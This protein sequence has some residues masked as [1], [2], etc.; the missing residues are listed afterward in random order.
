LLSNDGARIWKGDAAE[1]AGF[2]LSLLL[3]TMLA[4]R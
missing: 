3:V 1:K 4:D 2:A